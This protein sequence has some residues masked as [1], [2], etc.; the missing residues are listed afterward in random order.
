M[1][2]PADG[3]LFGTAGVPQSASGTSSLSGIREISRLGLDC[4]EVEFVKGIKMGSDTAKQLAQEASKEKVRLS[5]HAPYYINLNSPE[6]GKKLASQERILNSSRLAS[7]CGAQSVVFHPGY[8]GNG[9]PEKAFES[10]KK[11]L[12]EVVSILKLERTPVTLRPETMGR[13]S[14]FGTLEEILFLCREV[15]GLQP[16]IDFSHL[17]ARQ[18]KANS[19]PDFLRILSKISKKLGKESL[20]NMHIHISGAHYSDKGEIKHLN[21]KESDFNYEEW[22]QALKDMDVK[23]TVI[24][25]SPN[26]E[27]DALMLKELYCR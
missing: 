9:P 14:Q 12:D 18:K 17:H 15:D 24:C 25:E 6:E 23:G 11:G 16:C 22:I 5:V 27:Q 26:Q 20:Q 21:L 3:L 1:I 4:M 2:F 19:Y 8:Y 7:M 10:I 13:K